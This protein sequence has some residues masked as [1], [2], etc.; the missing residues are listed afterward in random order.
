MRILASLVCAAA[1]CSS[2]HAQY[3]TG[4]EAPQYNASAAGVVASGQ[5]GWYQPVAGGIDQNIYTYTGNA[6][7]LVQN[8]V[9]GNQFIG[10][11][12]GGGTL[13]ARAQINTDFG[14]SAWTIAYDFAGNWLGV[15]SSAIN[16]GSFSLQH[17][18]VP[19]GSFRQ[20]IAIKNFVDL[21]NPAAGMK[22][23]FNVFDAAGLAL[24]N[25]LPGPAWGNM[26]SNHWYRQYISFD[27]STNRILSLT[28]LDL[29]TGLS[30]TVTPDWYMTGGAASTL[31]LPNGVRFFVSGAEGNALGWD[32]LSVVP[33]PGTLG[34][35]AAG[36]VVGLRRRRA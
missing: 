3:Y 30:S 16:L 8:P 13:A 23:E 18:T 19:A 6:L 34:L 21:A 5:Q 2:V 12:S 9:G 29:H 15:G 11:R 27:L 7:G 28:L 14:P 20:F 36:L 35:L 31:A 22:L 24:N 1:A 26:Q 17:D 25:Q 4:F 33:A 32:N 10:G